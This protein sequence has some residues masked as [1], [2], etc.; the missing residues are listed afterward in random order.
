MTAQE[1]IRELQKVR[2]YCNATSIPAIDYAIEAILEKEDRASRESVMPFRVQAK[3]RMRMAG[4]MAL[5]PSGMQAIISL[6][7]M[8]RRMR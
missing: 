3:V 7:D 8:E 2:N 5:K 4:T 6:K 1:A